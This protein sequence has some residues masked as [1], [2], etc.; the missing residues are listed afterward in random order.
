MRAATNA[1]LALCAHLAALA[2]GAAPFTLAPEE[3][4]DWYD[5][6][7]EAVA[8][9]TTCGACGWLELLDW[10]PRRRL[11][12]YAL[13]AIRAADVALYLRD[14]ARGS[15]DVARARA[16]LEA[17]AA[18]AAPCERLVAL[19]L[20]ELRVVAVADAEPG[21]ALPAGAWAERIPAPAASRWFARL[22]LAED[23]PR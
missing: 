14:R 2:P 4:L 8:R 23:A 22:G 10:D 17:L 7:V 19:E 11:R 9:C 18:S 6:P 1:E 3:I 21:L 16:E 13:A 15:C 5:G 12:I 20:P